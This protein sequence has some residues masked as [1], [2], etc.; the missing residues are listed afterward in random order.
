MRT[1]RENEA[2]KRFFSLSGRSLAG[3]SVIALI[4]SGAF[5]LHLPVAITGYFYL[6]IVLTVTLVFGFWE[7]TV[8][9]VAA[10][11]CLDYFF[12]PPLFSFHVA[13]KQDLVLLAAF[14]STAL[15]VSR[16]SSRAQRNSRE[17]TVQRTGMAMLYELSRNVLLLP[18]Q[19]PPG[20]QLAQMIHQGFSLDGV[21][22][23]DVNSGQ[24]ESAGSWTGEEANLAKTAYL[25]DADHDDPQSHTYHRVLRLGVAPIGSLAV[26]GECGP[27]TINAIVSLAAIALERHRA[28]EKESRAEAARHS[29]QLRGAVLDSL[30]HAFKTP[31]TAIRTASSGLLEAGNLT[32]AQTDLVGLI[33]DESASLNDLCTRLLQTS[34]LEPEDLGVSK[35]NLLVSAVVNEVVAECAIKHSS[36]PIQ[37]SLAD[38]NLSVNGDRKLIAMIVSEYVS[39]AAK[40]S[41]YGSPIEIRREPADRKLSSGCITTVLRLS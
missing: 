12:T 6:L 17:T 29:E 31:L 26:R 34:K 5:P 40:Y 23:Y 20:P 14:E 1:L 19:L 33:D 27:L 7:A 2:L 3:L 30:A 39:N 25:M 16:L 13:K 24:V 11:G 18:I 35:E 38:D 4:T 22:L 36:H 15:I 28:F 8:A 37:V 9:S 32:L 41:S 21:S 10:A